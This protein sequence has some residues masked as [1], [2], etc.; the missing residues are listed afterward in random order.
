MSKTEVKE[1]PLLRRE[2]A[3]TLHT[4]WPRHSLKR[5]MKIEH[6]WHSK[7]VSFRG[8]LTGVPPSRICERNGYNCI[9]HPV[10][11]LTM[12]PMILV[13]DQVE[14]AL[15][16]IIDPPPVDQLLLESVTPIPAGRRW[17]PSLTLTTAVLMDSTSGGAAVGAT[18]PMPTSLTKSTRYASSLP[19]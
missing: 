7:S 16:G 13:T 5:T 2:R 10:P 1:E 18:S 11:N 15:L 9:N 4:S 8:Y 14:E 19:L 17:F 3:R 12:T 6:R